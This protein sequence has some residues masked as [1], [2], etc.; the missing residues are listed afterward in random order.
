MINEIDRGHYD[1]CRG[2]VVKIHFLRIVV[3]TR[4]RGPCIILFFFS[5]YRFNYSFCFSLP[6]RKGFLE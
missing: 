5:P 6:E 2:K 4:E 1:N 3:S